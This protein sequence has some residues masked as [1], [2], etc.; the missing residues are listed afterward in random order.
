MH[1]IKKLAMQYKDIYGY[2]Q[3]DARIS[4]NG[5][6]FTSEYMMVLVGNKILEE[7]D[8]LHFL[9][10]VMKCFVKPGLLKRHGWAHEDEQE[11]I[12]DYIAVAHAAKQLGYVNEIC[13]PILSYG[14]RNFWYYCNVE[15]PTV[16]NKISAAFWRFPAFVAHLYFCCNRNP[17]PLGLFFWCGAVVWSSF[18]SFK[19][20]DEWVLSWHMCNAAFGVNVL[21]DLIIKFWYWKLGKKRIGDIIG[22]YFNNYDHPNSRYF[23]NKLN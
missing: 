20:Q 13:G 7:E 5:L 11:G 21:S 12:D 14:Q 2:M 19:K 6:R 8:K 9:R 10:L 4:H 17:T 16:K 23:R 18:K 1:V 22:N 15:K 3:P